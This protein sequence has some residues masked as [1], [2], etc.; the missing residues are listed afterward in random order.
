[1]IAFF[2][3]GTPVAQSRPRFARRG[4]FVATYDA[5]PSKDYKS[6]VKS[7]AVAE[8]EK[9]GFTIINRDVPLKIEVVINLARPKSKPKRFVLPTT[10]PDCDN[11][12]KGL[13]D[14][15]E[16]IVYEADQQI[17]SVA[18]RKQYHVA[19]GV[20]IHISEFKILEFTP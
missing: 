3:P 16:S 8:M 19:V 9:T 10:K 1:M 2:I 12:L 7:C 17:V 14:A 13:Q 18:C 6:W 20:H 4:N 11:V 5:A 15:L